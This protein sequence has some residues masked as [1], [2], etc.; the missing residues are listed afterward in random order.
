MSKKLQGKV[1]V[2]TGSSKGIGAAIAKAL[3]AEGA[4]VVV[5]YSRGLSDAEKVVAEIQSHGGE[6]IAIRA[7]LSQPTRDRPAVQRNQGSLPA[8]R[9]L[10]STMPVS[11]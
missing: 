6:A 4:Q 1:A 2:V 10:W 7:D 8:L 5:N 9:H 11:T 3:A